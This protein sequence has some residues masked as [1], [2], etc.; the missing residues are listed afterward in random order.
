MKLVDHPNVVACLGYA[1]GALKNPE[2][3]YRNPMTGN[4]Y[5]RIDG[6]VFDVHPL[7]PETGGYP[8]RWELDAYARSELAIEIAEWADQAMAK[9][10]R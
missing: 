9:G 2:Q 6:R 3:T 10:W 4:L 5:A 8:I 1:C 7:D